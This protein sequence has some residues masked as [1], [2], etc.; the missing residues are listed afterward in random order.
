MSLF[1]NEQDVETI[2]NGCPICHLDV[3]GNEVYLY[4]CSHCNILFRKDDL[5]LDKRAVE[6]LL[7]ENIIKKFENDKDKIKIE[8]KRIK[9][10]KIDDKKKEL[11]K[12]LKEITKYYVSKKS[13]II[14]MSNCPY[15][16]NIKKENKI[17]L[18][19]LNGTEKFKKCKCM[20]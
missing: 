1:R 15:G 3:K 16:K 12:S 5:V 4:F 11:L 18:K 2:T 7:K 6:Q 13:N 10:I 20:I 17:L 19:S 14:H 9:E 8:E